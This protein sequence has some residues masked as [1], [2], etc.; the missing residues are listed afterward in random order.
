[1]PNLTKETIDSRS[2]PYNDKNYVFTPASAAEELDLADT[3]YRQEVIC[4]ATDYTGTV[5]LPWVAQARGLQYNIRV[6]DASNAIT[7]Q[8][9]DDSEDWEGDFTLDATDDYIILQSDGR[10]WNIVYNGIS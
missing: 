10:K 1:M 3:L 6:R 4:M 7:L 5:T 2:T 8:D 9:H